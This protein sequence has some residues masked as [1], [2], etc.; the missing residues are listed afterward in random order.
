MSDLNDTNRLNMSKN[1]C[2]KFGINQN[3]ADIII[4]EMMQNYM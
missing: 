4:R 1:A 3:N 2:N